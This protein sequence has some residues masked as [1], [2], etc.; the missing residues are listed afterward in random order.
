[1]REGLPTTAKTDDLDV[2]LTAAI[3]DALD[4]C[5][6]AGDVAATRENAIARLLGLACR[7]NITPA[8]RRRFHKAV[9]AWLW[10]IE[11]L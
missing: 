3:S 10:N 4:D 2:V 6:E 5:V 1:M 9:P 11:T 7:N 8:S